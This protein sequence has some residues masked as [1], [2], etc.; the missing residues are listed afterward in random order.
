[1]SAGK[2]HLRE[3]VLRGRRRTKPSLSRN[4]S[5]D[6]TELRRTLEEVFIELK[7]VEDVLIVCTKA[8]CATKVEQVEEVGNVLRR[9]G[10]DPLFVQ[11]QRLSKVI[12]G[13]GGETYMTGDTGDDE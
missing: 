1:M 9:S 6:N 8:Y 7:N 5:I 2:P 3:P 11:L 13:L 12:E 10:A 4:N